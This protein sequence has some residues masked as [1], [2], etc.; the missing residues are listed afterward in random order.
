MQFFKM[1]NST[2]CSS[3]SGVEMYFYVDKLQ[4][5]SRHHELINFITMP[6]LWLNFI[7]YFL[8]FVIVYN[9]NTFCI[10]QSI[11]QTCTTW[12]TLITKYF[13]V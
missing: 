9:I 5:T 3:T 12:E 1:V 4:E 10:W 6:A 11:L 8:D 13:V 7:I 2:Q